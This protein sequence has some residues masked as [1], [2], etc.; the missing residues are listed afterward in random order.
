M[1]FA[2]TFKNILKRFVKNFRF[3]AA[4]S[5]LQPTARLSAKLKNISDPANKQTNN[6]N[7]QS[8]ALLQ[9]RL[10]TK[11]DGF[12]LFQWVV[13]MTTGRGN[14]I[15]ALIYELWLLVSLS[16]NR[17][18][19]YE[20]NTEETVAVSAHTCKQ[21]LIYR[22]ILTPSCRFQQQKRFT[23]RSPLIK[24]ELLVGYVATV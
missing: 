23:L 9:Q 1:F 3:T 20:M 8:A 12:Y 19:R 21:R 17:A 16:H 7:Q 18:A 15:G 6:H 24:N 4:F 14:E 22:E 2:K 13:N 10:K 5:H 11:W